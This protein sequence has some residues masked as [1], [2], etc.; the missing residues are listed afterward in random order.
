MNNMNDK[1]S[2]AY[3]VKTKAAEIVAGALIRQAEQGVRE[4]AFLNFI[5]S[6]I[7]D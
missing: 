7:S 2:L 5:G 4:S 1:P 6:G 3:K